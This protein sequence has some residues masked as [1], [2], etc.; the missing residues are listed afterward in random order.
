MTGKRCNLSWN[1]TMAGKLLMT[2][3]NQ[4]EIDDEPAKISRQV[5]YT[6]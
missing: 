2:G 5:Y 4:W 3:G 1:L 6:E